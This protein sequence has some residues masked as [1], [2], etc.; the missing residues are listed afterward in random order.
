MALHQTFSPPT[1]PGISLES[2]IHT[3]DRLRQI[4]KADLHSGDLVFVKT[5]RSTYC[6]EFKASGR[7]EV[8]GG[9]FDQKGCSPMELGITGCTWGGTAI[10]IDIVAACGLRLEFANRL[11]TSPIQEVTV[12]RRRG[13]Q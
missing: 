8:S 3:V 13:S 1:V 7:Y 10:K 9:W 11:L 6:I 5:L 2:Q 4:R 12:F